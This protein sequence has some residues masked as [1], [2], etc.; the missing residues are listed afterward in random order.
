[1]KKILAPFVHPRQGNLISCYVGN[2]VQIFGHFICGGMFESNRKIYGA[3]KQSV[4]Y[5]W[6][7]KTLSGDIKTIPRQ[8]IIAWNFERDY[9]KD[10]GA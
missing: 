10:L 4:R 6:R 5:C 2:G 1:M 9:C 8:C 3:L 7:I